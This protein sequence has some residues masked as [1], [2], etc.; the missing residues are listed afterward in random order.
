MDKIILIFVFFLSFGICSFSQEWVIPFESDNEDGYF[1]EMITIDG[2]DAV[3]G[4]GIKYQD[5][6][7]S[8]GFI[9][10]IEKNGESIFQSIDMNDMKLQYHSAVQLSNGKYMVFGVC[11]D[12]ISNYNYQ[13]YLKVDIFNNQLE[14]TASKLYNVDDDVFDCISDSFWGQV[15]TCIFTKSNT[16]VLA[17]RLSYSY[18]TSY[19]TI[20]K[21][22]IRF[23]E[24]DEDGDVL[25]IV[26][27]DL[28]LSYMGSLKE[29]TYAPHSDNYILFVKGGHYPEGHSGCSG[30]FVVDPSLHVVARQHM[31]G[32]ASPLGLINDNA[33]D[34]KWIDDEY[35]ILDIEKRW[36]NGNPYRSL[37]KVDSALNVYAEL[38][39]PPLDDSC[40]QAPNGTTTAYIND[41]T[42]FELCYS[43]PFMF[44]QNMQQI[45]I[46]LVNKH[47]NLL[48]RKVIKRDDYYFQAGVPAA[49]NDG[50]CLV[51]LYAQNGSNYQGEPFVHKE[52]MKFRREDI[53]ITWDVVNETAAKPTSVAYPNPAASSLNIPINETIPNDARIQLF[54]A[55]GAKCLDSE[56]GNSGNLITLDVHNLDAGLYVYKVMSGKREVASGKFIKE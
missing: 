55:K 25:R 37:F 41:S 15:M 14:L 50:G 16:V 4:V 39:L 8:D 18:E 27:D 53:E 34:G 45:N 54:D 38:D 12:T 47:L 32:L 26:D 48:G 35:L 9:A 33:C 36:N 2:G 30:M 31:L 11:D 28:S 6:Q 56:A 52:L 42:I 29:I 19:G 10:R 13:K 51:F 44:A 17:I 21:G 20:Y 3:L 23:Y 24:F 43:R 7:Q 46:N 1:N 22:A 49:F 5:L 40:S